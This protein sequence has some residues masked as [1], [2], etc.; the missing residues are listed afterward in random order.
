MQHD[1][2]LYTKWGDDDVF[3]WYLPIKSTGAKHALW[4]NK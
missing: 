4:E 2:R 1:S 3:D